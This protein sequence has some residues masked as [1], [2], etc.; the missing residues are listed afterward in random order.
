MTYAPTSAQIGPNGGGTF[1]LNSSFGTLQLVLNTAGSWPNG[2]TFNAVP[3]SSGGAAPQSHRR[4]TKGATSSATWQITFTGA[5]GVGQL[6]YAP[7]VLFSTGQFSQSSYVIELIDTT[8]SSGSIIF[9]YNPSTAIEYEPA[10]PSF[11]IN[12]GDTYDLQVVS[13]SA[14][15]QAIFNYTG[16]SQSF[17]VPA[18]VTSLSVQAQG[19][20]GGGNGGVGGW[21]FATIPATPGA[22]IDVEVG[23]AGQASSGGYNGGASGSSGGGGASDVRV[24]GSALANRVIIAGGG[25]GGSCP[26][27]GSAG[28]NGG[29]AT[30]ANAAAMTCLGNASTDGGSG[31]TPSAGGTGGPACT[32]GGGSAA[33]GSAGA[34]GFGGA[35]ANGTNPGAGGGGGLYGGGGGG[36]AGQPITMS[37]SCGNLIGGGGGGGGSSY[38]E[39]SATNVLLSQGGPPSSSQPQGQPA[40]FGNG[41]VIITW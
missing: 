1:T 36:S 3:L 2:V 31:G 41:Q 8:S 18:G 5:S 29:G 6:A 26:S 19:A 33:A 32:T 24:G 35:G 4:A 28:G 17:T 21:T 9:Y 23:G 39:P 20:S 11:Q 7:V 16:G 14:H 13:G 37:Q 10:G 40:Q 38:A 34:L 15:G 12:L 30:G 22:A 25:G 27:I